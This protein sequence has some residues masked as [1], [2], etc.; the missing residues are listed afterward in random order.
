MTTKTIPYSHLE[1]AVRIAFENDKDI[2]KFYDK[3]VVVT[4]LDELVDDIVAKLK[5]YADVFPDTAFKIV[6]DKNKTVG[7]IVFKEDTLI[8]FGLSVEYRQR[9]YLN[10]F[11]ALIKKE[12][13]GRFVVMLWSRNIRA[14]KWLMKNGLKILDTNPEITTLVKS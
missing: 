4:T 1:P 9:K 11:F 14:V 8:S 12:L 7:Y 5:D 3:N 6:V 13:R 10:E 2:F